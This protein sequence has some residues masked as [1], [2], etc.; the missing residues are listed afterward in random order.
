MTA[1]KQK[2]P[3]KRSKKTTQRQKCQRK[4]K[5]IHQLVAL[6]LIR[7]PKLKRRRK[8]RRLLLKLKTNWIK[9]LYQKLLRMS[10]LFKMICLRQV[11][12]KS[13]NRNLKI[14]KCQNKNHQRRKTKNQTKQN[15]QWN[16]KKFKNKKPMLCK[17]NLMNI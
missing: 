16:Y 3:L 6:I 9:P 5:I 4:F 2:M 11:R 14:F 10:Q 1:K 12:K 7:E 13:L 15:Y 17:L 8:R